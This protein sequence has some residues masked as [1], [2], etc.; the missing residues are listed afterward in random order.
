MAEIVGWGCGQET[1]VSEN[2]ETLSAQLNPRTKEI[3]IYVSAI[4]VEL[5]PR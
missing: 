2:W 4:G 5:D 1:Y 3:R